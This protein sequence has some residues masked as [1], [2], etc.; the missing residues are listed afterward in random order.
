MRSSLTPEEAL[1]NY[2]ALGVDLTQA[3]PRGEIRSSPRHRG[4]C[5]MGSIEV[6]KLLRLCRFDAGTLVVDRDGRRRQ[7]I[8]TGGQQHGTPETPLRYQEAWNVHLDFPRRGERQSISLC[9]AMGSTTLH[10]IFRRV[11]TDVYKDLPGT[12]LPATVPSW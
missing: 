10:E 8:I 4:R 3:A 11:G 1:R 2:V 6:G 9:A 5:E 7:V 12:S